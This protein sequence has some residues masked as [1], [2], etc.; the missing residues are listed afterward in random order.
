MTFSQYII[1]FI[2]V[3]AIPLWAQYRV[4]TTY[5][6]SSKVGVA[7]G[8]T[9]AEDAR[10]ILDT[11]GLTNVPVRETKGIL[12]DNYDPRQKAVF[13]SEANFRGRSIAVAVFAA[14][15]VGHAI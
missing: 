13:L 6:H 3:A 10:H 4:N 5:A 1:Y 2:I 15:V 14:H 8:L 9:G 12:S 11:N 7:N